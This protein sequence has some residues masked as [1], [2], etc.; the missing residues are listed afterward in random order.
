M[1]KNIKTEYKWV[2]V[3]KN[4]FVAADGREF[5]TEKECLVYEERSEALKQYFEVAK[6][7]GMSNE[8]AL[9]AFLFIRRALQVGVTL[10]STLAK[11][12]RNED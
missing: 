2:P 11:E 7:A 10:I 3:E 12:T 8:E 5:D 1:I 6:N 4:V 9:H